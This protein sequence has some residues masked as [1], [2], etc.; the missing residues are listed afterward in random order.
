MKN[1]HARILPYTL[2]QKLSED[3]LKNV[4]A[5]GTSEMTNIATYGRGSGTDIQIDCS[6]DI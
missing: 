4:S 6:L 1:Q 5:A 2:S 3:D